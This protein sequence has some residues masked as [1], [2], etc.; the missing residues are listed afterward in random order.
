[1]GCDFRS[2]ASLAWKIQSDFGSD[3]SVLCF[4]G[5]S[6]FLATKRKLSPKIFTKSQIQINAEHKPLFKRLRKIVPSF[7]P[8]GI[9]GQKVKNI[10]RH[11]IS[12]ILFV[13]AQMR[14]KKGYY[15]I[16]HVSKTF[17][18]KIMCNIF[19]VLKR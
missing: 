17:D 1:M 16:T 10:L 14:R 6:L 5:R 2:V 8:C 18:G 12:H 4:H 9:I 15:K 19:E 13:R 11:G 3:T 7:R